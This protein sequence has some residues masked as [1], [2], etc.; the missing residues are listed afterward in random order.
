[1]PNYQLNPILS[2]L[3]LS[4]ASLEQL[5]KDLSLNI[6]YRQIDKLRAE[7]YLIET[8][9]DLLSLKTPFPYHIIPEKINH[10]LNDIEHPEILFVDHTTST[11][12]L[13]KEILLTH[14]ESFILM[15]RNQSSGR[16][17]MSRSWQMCADHDIAMTFTTP[18]LIKQHL[19]FSVIRL[20]SL[21]IYRTLK[22]YTPDIMIKW[23]ND[24]ITTNGKKI[25]GILTETILGNNQIQYLIIGIGININSIDLPDYASSLRKL[26]QTFIDINQIYA[27]IITEL[28]S[29]WE[30][31]PKNEKKI[32]QEWEK[33]L[34]W[35][36]ES[37]S[38][39]W[40]NKH[41]QGIL[42]S[43][44]EDGSLILSIDQQDTTFFAGD[45]SKI[46]LRKQ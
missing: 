5:S 26:S 20:T 2:A 10:L 3:L 29:L 44:S 1:M 4:P 39:N 22:R 25:C 24:L 35:I 16:G 17:R 32:S 34:A 9:H 31:F 11:N 40:N 46:T 6:V 38:L 19:L 42:K 8:K 18:C 27:E 23:P 36:G 37:V 15:T 28:S 13:A 43:V 21:A 45:L 33:S 7:A 41:Y 30:Y 12:T 14:P